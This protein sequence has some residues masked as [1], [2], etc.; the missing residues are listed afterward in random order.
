MR[1]IPQPAAAG[2]ARAL[3]AFSKQQTIISAA[4]QLR[5]NIKTNTTLC[6]TVVQRIW[7]INLRRVEMG[8]AKVTP[9]IMCEL[10]HKKLDVSSRGEQ[11]TVG[12][13]DSAFTIWDRALCKPAVQEVV[14]AQEEYRENSIFNESSKL[15]ELVSKAGTDENIEWVFSLVADYFEAEIIT[16]DTLSL[17]ALQGKQNGANGKGIV[18]LL[19]FKKQ[20]LAY[21]LDALMP[22]KTIPAGHK[23]KIREVVSSVSSF[24][25]HIGY[26][27]SDAHPD[28]SWKA[29]WLP[30][31]DRMLK[32][33]EDSGRAQTISLCNIGCFGA[34]ERCRFVWRASLAPKVP[35]KR[36]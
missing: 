26:P 36:R 31:A 22:T 8:G 12:F 1:T 7:D 13:I 3:H 5:E 18:H 33:I 14:L 21:F 35:P 24:R 11:L 10:Y 15:Q 34:W 2:P 17:R 25:A 30:S 28:L 4:A 9:T 20:M 32:I 19:V 29:G 6:R 16:H 27:K 23:A